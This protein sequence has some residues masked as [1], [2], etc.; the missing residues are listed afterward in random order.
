MKS[1]IAPVLIAV[2]AGCVYAPQ[3]NPPAANRTTVTLALPYDLAWDAVQTVVA[4][5]QFHIVTANP[6]DGTLEA[7]APVP[8]TLQDADCGALRGIAGKVNEEPDPDSSAVYD[9]TIKPIEREQSTVSVAATFTAPLHVPLRPLSSVHC[10]SRGR[11]E[12]R[13]LNEIQIEATREHRP[14]PTHGNVLK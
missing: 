9:F 4:N 10:V 6:N 5:N 14:E 8:F 7:E 3:Q 1:R 2:V 11:Q 12:A 13:L